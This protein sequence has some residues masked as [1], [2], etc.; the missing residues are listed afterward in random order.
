MDRTKT[1]GELA[2]PRELSEVNLTGIGSWLLSLESEIAIKLWRKV[3]G[4]NTEKH[5]AFA[6]KIPRVNLDIFFV[7]RALEQL[8]SN[9]RRASN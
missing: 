4:L 5:L 6:F 2:L 8:W 7:F 3:R 1:S 9:L